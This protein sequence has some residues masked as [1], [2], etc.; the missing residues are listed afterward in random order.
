MAFLTLN[1]TG[2]FCYLE[3]FKFELS[4]LYS[5]PMPN[6]IYPAEDKSTASSLIQ[7]TRNCT[8]RFQT[9][10]GI[11]VIFFVNQQDSSDEIIIFFLL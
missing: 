9:A 1:F 5:Y 11:A 10:A 4:N 8:E 6:L 3:R 7:G 2:F